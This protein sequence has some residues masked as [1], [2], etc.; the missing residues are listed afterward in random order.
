M[1]VLGRCR[2]GELGGELDAAA[3]GP[4][5]SVGSVRADIEQFRRNCRNV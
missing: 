2:G 4:Q 5:A 3:G 1:E